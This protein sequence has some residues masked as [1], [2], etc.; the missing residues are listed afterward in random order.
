[1]IY[2]DFVLTGSKDKEFLKYT[3]PAIQE[4]TRLSR[5]SLIRDG[6]G[7]PDNDGYPDK[8]TT[9]WVGRGDSAY[10]GSLWLG[11]VARRGGAREGT[12][13]R[14]SGGALQRTVCQ[15]A[16]KAISRNCGTGR[17]SATTRRANTKITSQA[18]QLAGQWVRQT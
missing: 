11:F 1:M 17:T 12:W 9:K 15:R 10:S 14:E 16:E 4:S 5:P 8:L 18:D 13:R 6:D 7:I 3:W 2:R